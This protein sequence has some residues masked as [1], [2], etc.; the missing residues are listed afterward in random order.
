MALVDDI[1]G[2]PTA[3][4]IPVGEALDAANA[5][6]LRILIAELATQGCRTVV[7]DLQVTGRIDR[8]GVFVLVGAHR[9]LRGC[10]G[11]LAIAAAGDRV[12]RTLRACGLDRILR[13]Y[14][15][16][17]D[18]ARCLRFPPRSGMRLARARLAN[19]AHPPTHMRTQGSSKRRQVPLDSQLGN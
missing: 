12:T 14:A 3:E 9:R 19:M 1:D 11:T 6:E 17:E 7:L 15:T 13:A 18:A 5:D 4:I 10:G 2:S 8:S 16:V